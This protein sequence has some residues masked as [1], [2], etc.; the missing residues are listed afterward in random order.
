[1]LLGPVAL[2]YVSVTGP[3]GPMY[4]GTSLLGKGF[5]RNPSLAVNRFQASVNGLEAV[6]VNLRL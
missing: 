4:M 2:L 1:V 5:S 3:V 6:N